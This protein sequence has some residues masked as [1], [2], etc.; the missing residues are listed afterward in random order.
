MSQSRI[1][2]DW[3]TTRLRLWLIQNG[4]VVD[5]RAGPGI[6]HLGGTP[7]EALEAAIAP[8]IADNPA[9]RIVLCGMV[10]ARNGLHEV[11]YVACPL[12]AV[13]WRGGAADLVVDGLPV[14]IAAGAAWRHE[15]ARVDVMRGEETQIFG[16]MRLD[17]PLARGR[18]IVLLP[19][20]H[21]KWVTLDAGCLTEI[22]TFLTGEVF[23]LLQGSSLLAAGPERHA[24]AASD[25][26]SSGLARGRDTNGLLGALFETRTAQLCDGKGADWAHEF[27]SGLL[28]GSELT[29]V[30]RSGHLPIEVT[31]IGGGDL[32][33]RYARALSARN[34]KARLLDGDACARA[35]LD[36]LDVDG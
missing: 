19:G 24:G 31:I 28:L 30:D 20:T 9:A 4:S 2:G 6:G 36:L 22:R 5:S 13:R 33:R 25:G 27:L 34:V 29:E 7:R 12:D 15:D 21:S 32:A 10:G 16:A 11:P 17:P 14:R 26:F 3:G 35:G 1:L 8:W 18:N 23:A